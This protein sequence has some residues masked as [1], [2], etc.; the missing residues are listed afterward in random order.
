MRVRVSLRAWHS[1]KDKAG[2][3]N[4]LRYGVYSWQLFSHKWLRYLAPVFHLT[5]LASN[6]FLA[7]EG[8]IWN[9]LLLGQA[10]FYGL[11]L[12]GHRTGGRNMPSLLVFPYYFCLLKAA[13]GV[14]LLKFLAGRKQVLWAP[15]T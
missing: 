7:G 6:L 5:L 10:V 3:L 12:Y 11:A 14:A 1:L 15:R 8:A 2:L 9:L 13:A 4:I